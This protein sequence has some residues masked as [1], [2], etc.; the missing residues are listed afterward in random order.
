MTYF[1]RSALRRV[2]RPAFFTLAVL[3]SAA[4]WAAPQADLH[5]AV[6][7]A[8]QPYL[9]TLRD[10][11]HIESGSRDIEGLRQI[12]AY[13]AEKLRAQGGKVEVLEA[14]DVYRMDDTPEQFGPMVHATFQGKGKARIMLIAHMDTVYP[15]GMLEKQPFRIDGD[16]AYGLGISDDK[17][18][19]ALILQITALLKQ[20]GIDDFGTLTVLI[21][22]D[23]EISSPASRSTITRL[24]AQQDAVF[25][26]EGGG[27]DGT[28]VWPPAALV[29][30]T[31]R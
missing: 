5:A 20:Q 15:K 28:C 3:C 25:S 26:F 29:R 24:G 16:K 30:R 10:L 23:E 13:I 27:T 6:Q 18:G 19:V 22:G 14:S 2:A 8:Q 11:V 7:K 9:D 1:V 31:S 21:N 4:A 17:Q 12:A